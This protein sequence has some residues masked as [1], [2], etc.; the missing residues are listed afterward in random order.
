MKPLKSIP[1]LLILFLISCSDK[2]ET[3]APQNI[4]NPGIE[5]LRP[6]KEKNFDAKNSQYADAKNIIKLIKKKKA[7]FI[8]FGMVS[9]DYSAFEKKYG[10]KVKTENCVILPNISK[11]ATENNKIISKYLSQKFQDDWKSDL[12]IVPFGLN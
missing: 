5:N 2:N 10:I 1:V 6:K 3:F 4:L 7:S 11:L 9:D 12:K 8:I